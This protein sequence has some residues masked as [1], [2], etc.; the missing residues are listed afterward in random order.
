M[1]SKI[2]KPTLKYD[3]DALEP[4]ISKAQLDTHFNKH[5]MGYYNNLVKALEDA[6]SPHKDKDLLAIITSSDGVLFN[7]AAQVFNHSF[8]FDSMKANKESKPNPPTGKIAEL[9]D[10]DFGSFDN[11]KAEFGKAAAGHFGSGWAWLVQEDGK[12]VITSTHDAHTPVEGKDGKPIMACD[13]WEHAYYLDY[14]NLR[15]QY[16]D[17][18]WML[19]NWENANHNLA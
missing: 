9:I 13:V 3:V 7:Q 18:W 14:K 10:R 2:E 12:L 17:A 16:I 1:A 5:H 4:H 11:F 19:V 6:N 8:Y 15:A